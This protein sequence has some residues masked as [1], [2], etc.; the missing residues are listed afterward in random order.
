MKP[1]AKQISALAKFTELF[2]AGWIYEGPRGARRLLPRPDREH[3]ADLT[4]IESAAEQLAAAEHRAPVAEDLRHAC[5]LLA[6]GKLKR[7]QDFTDDD[8]R[9][10]IDFIIGIL[11]P[12][13]LALAQRRADPHE[14]KHQRMIWVLKNHCLLGYVISE[15]LRL[16]DTRDFAALPPDQFVK[17]YQHLHAR[18][19]AWKPGHAPKPR[20]A[21]SSPSP[22]REGRGEGGRVGG[23]SVPVPAGEWPDELPSASDDPY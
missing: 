22:G 14:A 11:D 3:H 1:T 21:K 12:L 15:S 7:T 8:C 6:L 9:A 4:R 5:T 23:H 18:P 13:N 10:I 20:R 17:F 2:R 16:H 19:N